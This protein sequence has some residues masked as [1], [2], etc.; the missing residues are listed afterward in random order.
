MSALAADAMNPTF[1][2]IPFP[3]PAGV[4]P[5]APSLYLPGAAPAPPNSTA[6]R[7]LRV[8]RMR[9][10]KSVS[11]ASETVDILPVARP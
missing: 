1:Q 4:G 9:A 3:R 2:S 6:R 8:S 7:E 11:F 10:P 5:V